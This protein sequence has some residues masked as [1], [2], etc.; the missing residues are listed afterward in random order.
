MSAIDAPSKSINTRTATTTTTTSSSSLLF[1]PRYFPTEVLSAILIHI[2]PHQIQQLA[3][4]LSHTASPQ[5]QSISSTFSFAVKNINAYTALCHDTSSLMQRLRDLEWCKLPSIYITALIATH[6]FTHQVHLILL[7]HFKPSSTSL[8]TSISPSSDPSSP[9]LIS[10]SSSLSPISCTASLSSPSLCPHIITASTLSKPDSPFSTNQH[11]A[12]TWASRC[13]HTDVVSLILSSKHVD[14]TL[15][16]NLPIRMAAK[17]GHVHVVNMILEA[18]AANTISHPSRSD[19]TNTS[20]SGYTHVPMSIST[21][22]KPTT[23]TTCPILS[24]AQEAFLGAASAG[25]TSIIQHLL[26]ETPFIIDPSVSNNL[27]LREACSNGHFGVVECLLKALRIDGG[28]GYHHHGDGDQDQDGLEEVGESGIRIR[29]A[30]TQRDRVYQSARSQKFLDMYPIVGK[31]ISSSNCTSCSRFTAPLDLSTETQEHQHEHEHYQD[32]QNQNHSQQ[33]SQPDSTSYT[34]P[35][36]NASE[37]GFHQIVRLLLKIPSVNPSLHDSLALRTACE[38]GH[39]DVVKVLLEDGRVDVSARG[40]QALN[41]A[42]RRGHLG[43]VQL[44]KGRMRELGLSSEGDQG[45]G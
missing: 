36:L 8:S 39:Y 27:A 9:I 30:R 43:I 16:G 23:T 34:L 13:G 37:F 32:D 21:S 24:A 6:G 19:E 40:F 11:Y 44:V 10:P 26:F 20:D 41:S 45:E 38:Y 18:I 35:L 7:R 17:G 3:S 5:L 15:T 1:T 29:E 22:N 12:L 31:H 33:H 4:C 14:P 2:H 28:G 25:S 42:V